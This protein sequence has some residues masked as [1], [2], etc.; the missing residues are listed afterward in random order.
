M[1]PECGTGVFVSVYPR[2]VAATV[3]LGIQ[4]E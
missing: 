1:C 4:S 2:H 3:I